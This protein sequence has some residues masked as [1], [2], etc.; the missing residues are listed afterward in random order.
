MKHKMM[1]KMLAASVSAT[2]AF[3]PLASNACTASCS[4]EVMAVLFTD[5]QWSLV[6]SLPRR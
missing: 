6:Y 2:L 3:A 5:V 4:K 1:K